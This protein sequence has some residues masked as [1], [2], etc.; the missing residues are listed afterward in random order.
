MLMDRA[1]IREVGGRVATQLEACTR[2]GIC[3]EACPFYKVI[4]NPEYTPIWKLELLRRAYEQ[5]FTLTGKL[6]RAM[7]LEK[8]IT[9]ADLLHWRDLNYAACSTCNKCSMACPMGITVGLLM[10]EMR[11]ALAEAGVVPENLIKIQATI[12]QA[13]NI[14]GYPA[15]ERT[16]WVEYMSDAPD[17]LYLREQAEVIYFTGCV[18][19][20]SPTAQRIA[21]AVVRVL[22]AAEVNFTLLGE[23]EACCGFPLKAAGLSQ[24]AAE[25]I[26]KNV[27]AIAATGART[28]VFS[29]PACRLTWLREYAP[30]LPQIR[31]LHT[32]EFMAEL[33]RAG[34][35]KLQ[36]LESS[37]TYHDPCDLARNGGV[38]DAPREV[39][40]A[41]P[42]LT[43]REVAERRT[44]GLCC[45]G[46]GNVEAVAP[47]HVNRVGADAVKKLTA[48][49]AQILAT[50]C[51]QCMRVFERAIKE[52]NYN[53]TLLDVA[54]IVARSI[55]QG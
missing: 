26:K 36:P 23:K 5:N 48:T 18:V 31:P 37:V 9:E 40:Q 21:E 34:K 45:G 22:T 14:F 42:A 24:A 17:D 7:G 8:P 33:I 44:S 41:I 39:L 50:A 15:Y 30:L 19:A 1:F 55:G 27:E 10:H 6:K 13:D 43:L 51:P 12:A 2:C 29:C 54:E 11:D 16:G 35:L 20:F 53:V 25:L 28:I 47:D 49:G 52:A 32:T 4:G 38:Y 3:A 46:G